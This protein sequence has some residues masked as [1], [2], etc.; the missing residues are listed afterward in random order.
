[1]FGLFSNKDKTKRTPPP[2]SHPSD[3]LAPPAGPFASGWRVSTGFVG[4]EPVFV[5]TV[6]GMVWIG[7]QG[8]TEESKRL[9][10]FDCVTGTPGRE[11]SLPSVLDGFERIDGPL[12]AQQPSPG[13]VSVFDIEAGGLAFSSDLKA[14]L[15]C[16]HGGR[17]LLMR[18]DQDPPALLV[19]DGRSGTVR[20]TIKLGLGVKPR[21]ELFAFGHTAL[22]LAEDRLLGIDLDGGRVVF[23]KLLKGYAHTYGPFDAEVFI[24]DANCLVCIDL[25][26]GRIAWQ[27]EL[28]HPI[29]G[30]Q[31]CAVAVGR[32]RLHVI[33][34]IERRE[35]HAILITP[36]DRTTGKQGDTVDRKGVRSL[37]LEAMLSPLPLPRAVI[38]ERQIDV[39]FDHDR[40]LRL[41]LPAGT[42]CR[43]LWADGRLFVLG[44]ELL[45]IDVHSP[46]DAAEASLMLA[47]VASTSNADAPAEVTFVGTSAVIMVRHPLY[48]DTRVS[49]T[50]SSPHIKVGDRLILEG[51]TPMPGGVVKIESWKL[52]DA[53]QQLMTV[54]LDARTLPPRQPPGPKQGDEALL[55]GPAEMDTVPPKRPALAPLVKPIE[56]LFG[57]SSIPM[58]RKLIEVCDGAPEVRARWDSFSA[59]LNVTPYEPEVEVPGLSELEFSPFAAEDDLVFYGVVREPGGRGLGI[60]VLNAEGD[61]DFYW[62]T[63]TFESWFADLLSNSNPPSRVK[64]MLED[65]S[66]PET[67]LETPRAAVPTWFSDRTGSA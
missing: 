20:H 61:N 28:A 25:A 49:R 66:L 26:A 30:D 47:S 44:R 5:G 64:L 46:P 24:A 1:M 13:I 7:S 41:P 38:A 40:E 60:A 21:R 32:N 43:T 9:M 27:A 54:L 63:D 57:G 56:Q 19:A 53:A 16:S 17:M 29:L 14:K 51:V 36:F 23:K 15:V 3:V 12:I 48:G 39:H 62:S 2:P 35:G 59:A 65:L 33:G 50:A 11:L 10:S 8:R 34:S 37:P 52:A 22:L 55:F 4:P 31:L 18:A 67:F 45:G 58:L 6:G 42:F